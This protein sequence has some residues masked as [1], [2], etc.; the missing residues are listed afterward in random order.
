MKF[1]IIDDDKFERDGLMGLIGKM[2]KG[3]EFIDVRNEKLGLEALVKENIDIVITDI[4]MPVMDGMQFLEK[5]KEIKPDI[6]YIIYSGYNDFAYAKQALSLNVLDFLVKPVDE[7]EFEEVMEKAFLHLGKKRREEKKQELLRLLNDENTSSQNIAENG[8]RLAIFKAE[9]KL[10]DSELAEMEKIS[11]EFNNT[12]VFLNVVKRKY[13]LWCENISE[14]F[15]INLIN[16][17]LKI[18]QG[19]INVAVSGKIQTNAGIKEAFVKLGNILDGAIFVNEKNL[20]L[21]EMYLNEKEVKFDGDIE[22]F[23]ENIIK[24]ESYIS[25]KKKKLIFENINKKYGVKESRQD[26]IQTIEELKDYAA[27]FSKDKDDYIVS[28]IKAFIAENYSKEITLEDIAGFVYLNSAYLCG[29]FKKKTDI[30]L[31][32]YLT[33]Y[34]MDKAKEL[35]AE[36]N[37]KSSDVALAVGYKNTSYFN[38]VF[39]QSTGMTPGEYKRVNGKK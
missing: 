35:F 20:I 15:V 26:E 30:T 19:R 23:I 36:G 17:V 39:K 11:F 16:K 13:I 29:V 33:V 1:L 21:P 24:V 32:K 2:D 25:P 18:Y 14:L 6:V 28:K 31:I 9:N 12:A 3:S 22:A 37:I 7:E 38:S 8:G 10:T 5:A 27:S 34:R 4:K